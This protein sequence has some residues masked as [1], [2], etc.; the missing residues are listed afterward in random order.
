MSKK[1]IG[2]LVLVIIIIIG[3]T[4]G[5]YKK[6]NITKLKVKKGDVL[7]AI[8]GLGKVQARQSFDVKVGIM[9]NVEKLFVQEG[10]KVEKGDKLIAFSSL[11]PFVA[12]FTGTVTLIELK[13]GEV[14]LPQIPILR[15][16]NLEDKYIEVSLEQDAALRVQRD[17][18]AQII[19]DNSA[20]E[21]LSGVVKSVYPKRG[22]FIAHIESS[23]IPAN[24]LP[25]MTADVV[26][27]VGKKKNVILIPVKAVTDARVVRLRNDKK[28]VI[29]VEIGSSDG[30]WAEVIS[31]DIKES[32]QL[33]IKGKK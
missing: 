6:K 18:K 17:Q 27:E 16:E 7:E 28:E 30:I 25:G 23:S 4:I 10:E 8:Y 19:F 14:A 13:V 21:K 26:I 22:E 33:V 2:L 12:P 9:T 3:T 5:F 15:L 11:S 32:D 20:G 1:L 29:E 24:I 31:G